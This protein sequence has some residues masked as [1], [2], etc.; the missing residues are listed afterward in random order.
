M[1]KTLLDLIKT[2]LKIIES[3]K[4]DSFHTIMIYSESLPSLLVQCIGYIENKINI[5]AKNKELI[6]TD[7][8][9]YQMGS[10]STDNITQFK[11]LSNSTVRSW[12]GKIQKKVDY[13][14]YIKEYKKEIID[15]F[16]SNSNQKEF[17]IATQ[18]LLSKDHSIIKWKLAEL[19]N[20]RDD[21]AHGKINSRRLSIISKQDF[22]VYFG[23]LLLIDKC[24]DD[25]IAHPPS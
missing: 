6:D 22:Y 11:N 15:I 9:L 25:I 17:E 19:K 5:F 23:I 18:Y 13:Q 20:Y 1:N 7:N 21:F 4:T 3:C 2:K 8:K 10:L 16:T 14:K 12:N 24:I